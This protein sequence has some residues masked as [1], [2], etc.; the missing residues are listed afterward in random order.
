[1]LAV[2]SEPGRFTA[3]IRIAFDDIAP[4]GPV[5]TG[6]VYLAAGVEEVDSSLGGQVGAD[7]TKYLERQIAEGSGRHSKWRGRAWAVQQQEDGQANS[8]QV[9]AQQ[10][11][12]AFFMDSETV[13]KPHGGSTVCGALARSHEP[14]EAKR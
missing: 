5:V 8:L 7:A 14:G 3:E 1:M 2:G 13:S 12:A 6:A 4:N 10:R 11:R 9:Y